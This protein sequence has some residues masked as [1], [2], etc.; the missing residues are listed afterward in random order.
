MS[1]HSLSRR[2]FLR[3][4]ASGAATA[5]TILQ[6]RFAQAE[7]PCGANVPSD[8]QLTESTNTRRLD[9]FGGLESVHFDSSGFF[10]VEK[11]D[12]WWLVTPDGAAFLS[13]GLNH[14]DSVYLLQDYNIDF[15]RAAFGFRDPSE[16]AFREGFIKKVMTDLTAFGMNT[17]GTHAP[18]EIFGKLTVPYV[19]GLFFVRTPYWIGPSARDFSDVFSVEFEKHCQRVAQR[20]VVPR[21]EDPFLIGYTLT[22]CPI[23]T[24]LDADAHGQDPWG[25]P[26]EALPT[27]PRVLRNMG[28]DE[29]GKKVFVSLVRKRYPTIQ[30]FNPVYRTRFSS[31]DELLD[32]ENWSP[33][34]KTAGI[35][36][37]KDNRAFLMSIVER[38]YAVA[39]AA[40]RKVDANHLIFGDI[41]N[42]QTT[43]PDEVVSLIAGHTDLIA[44]QYYGGYDDLGHQRDNEDQWV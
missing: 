2:D 39:C 22:D 31:F 18:K 17:I 44:Y 38:Y 5:A 41:L 33:V 16:P 20:L 30:E 29:P 23:L 14:A 32:S 11:A 42:A 43:T 26:S 40:I 36:D 4:S 10:R 8:K 6:H 34:K 7:Q 3:L 9:R 13:F 27:W 19:Q 28:P 15:W 35:G 21:K 12:R 37:A 24:D 1:I 25:G